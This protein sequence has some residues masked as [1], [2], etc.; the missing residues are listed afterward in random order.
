M[1]KPSGLLRPLTSIAAITLAAALSSSAAAQDAFDGM[2][3]IEIVAETGECQ[4]R[5]VAIEV[6]D[7]KVMFAGFGATA[8]G[9]VRSNG[10]VKAALIRGETVVTARGALDEEVGSGRWR[11]EDCHGSWTARRY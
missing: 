7:G 11:S 1:A 10:R 5:T 4:T 2:W 8:E 9:E 6:A 3:S